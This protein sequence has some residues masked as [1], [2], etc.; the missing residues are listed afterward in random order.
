MTGVGARLQLLPN[1]LSLARLALVPMTLWLI[2]HEHWSGAFWVFV[3][4][5]IT[6]ALDGA[7][8]RLLKAQTILG[9]WLDP[10]ADKVLVVTIY[11]SLAVTGDLPL[12]LVVLVALRDVMI[13]I[14]AVA[15][16]ISGRLPGR[17]VLISKVNTLAQIILASLVLARLG[18]GW[19]DVML[20]EAFII[21]VALTTT[22]SGAA[23]LVA[24]SQVRNI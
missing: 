21:V 12:W 9:A 15:D 19:G 24:A 23:Y 17:P 18:M 11:L 20:T 2:V 6:D 13:V 3:A 7:L 22:A 8:A 1:I 4:A 5:G 10:L 14:Y 16:L